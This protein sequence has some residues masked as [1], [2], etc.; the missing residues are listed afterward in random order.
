MIFP[1]DFILRRALKRTFRNRFRCIDGEM[2]ESYVIRGWNLGVAHKSLWLSAKLEEGTLD[3]IYAELF[4]ATTG[5]S[6]VIVSEQ[7]RIRFVL[8]HS[9]TC[10]C[11]PRPSPTRSCVLFFLGT[12]WHSFRSPGPFCSSHMSCQISRLSN[13]AMKLTS[14]LAPYSAL[15]FFLK[16]LCAMDFGSIQFF[17]CRY[18]FDSP[19]P[20]YFSVT[21]GGLK[22]P[23]KW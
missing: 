21:V 7:P 11:W 1:L 22:S 19:Y 2:I 5:A 13:A 23:L 15:L 10:D 6:P 4:V 3:T 14:F 18:I 9:Q 8:I 17:Q 12:S 16:T 20:F